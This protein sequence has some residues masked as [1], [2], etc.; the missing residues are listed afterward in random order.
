[1]DEQKVKEIYKELYEQLKELKAEVKLRKITVPNELSDE[2]NEMKQLLVELKEKAAEANIYVDEEEDVDY[3]EDSSNDWAQLIDCSESDDGIKEALKAHIRSLGEFPSA[4]QA[5]DMVDIID[6]Y[7]DTNVSNPSGT[8]VNE[9]YEK[10]FGKA[11]DK[12]EAASIEMYQKSAYAGI[13][14]G[15]KSITTNWKIQPEVHFHI[16]FEAYYRNQETLPTKVADMLIPLQFKIDGPTI[17]WGKVTTLGFLKFG[18][19][20]IQASFKFSFFKAPHIVRVVNEKVFGTCIDTYSQVLRDTMTLKRVGMGLVPEKLST[21]VY[22]SGLI[23]P[24]KEY[25][26]EIVLKTDL[27]TLNWTEIREKGKGAL[28]FGAVR[29]QGNFN[30][31]DFI[32]KDKW[33]DG[34]I[35]TRVIVT[36]SYGFNLSLDP[37]KL[38]DL[39]D[40]EFK[41]KTK[42]SKAAKKIT[43]L[44]ADDVKTLKNL[45]TKANELGTQ[46]EKIG[47]VFKALDKNPPGA[48][49]K[50]LAESFKK[51]S[52][53]LYEDCNKLMKKSEAAEKAAK[54]LLKEA[55]EKI[56]EKI[57]AQALK[58]AAK[59]LGRAI[60]VVNVVLTLIDVGV[61]VYGI[62]TYFNASKLRWEDQV[63]EWLASWSK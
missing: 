41:K 47:D 11:S 63:A 55:T 8:R 48:D 58:A 14:K 29:L 24:I 23:I 44:D 39:V 25:N 52:E 28:S 38:D 51:N 22:S 50:E 33:P 53:K 27:G 10:I 15:I 20:T 13:K 60:P 7:Y 32:T 35:F 16:P 12:D 4:K 5:L 26:S 61:V 18:E 31:L 34:V 62:Y 3:T 49:F 40:L 17:Q 57:G 37:F 9:I 42:L 54:K 21:T 56:T 36:L 30:L 2:L 6:R 59:M 43:E 19:P 1:M 46:A 45:Q